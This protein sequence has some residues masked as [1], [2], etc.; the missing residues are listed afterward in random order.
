MATPCARSARPPGHRHSL[1]RTRQ[2][3]SAHRTYPRP[4]S[5]SDRDAGDPHT[6]TISVRDREA[7]ARGVERHERHDD[8]VER[9]TVPPC[10]RCSAPRGHRHSVRSRR[11]HRC[12][13]MP[14]GAAGSP[15]L[16][17]WARTTT[18]ITA[19]RSAEQ[20]HPP[21]HTR[22]TEMARMDAR[23]RCRTPIRSGRRHPSRRTD[24]SR[25]PM[26]QPPSEGGTAEP[27]PRSVAS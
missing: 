9:S 4:R 15:G 6:L 10:S 18:P 11:S 14:S 17:N 3:P 2:P 26:P 25:Q 19:K 21:R 12:A 1:H 22:R 5:V 24:P 13:V 23:G 27:V 7:G 20:E 8:E 16:L